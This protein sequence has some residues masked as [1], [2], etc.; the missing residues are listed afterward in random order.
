MKFYKCKTCGK[1]VMVTK[2][3]AGELV[4]CGQ[5]MEEIIPH[6]IEF[7][8]NEKHIPVYSQMNRKVNVKIGSIL[9]PSFDDH[10]IEWIMVVTNKG[11]HLTVLKPGEIPEAQFKLAK[12]EKILAIYEYCSIHSLWKL[13]VTEE[14]FKCCSC[15]D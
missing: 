9:H 13:E 11:H 3:G 4:C 8:G 7:E 14:M 10:Y 6:T 5:P 12:D 15:S 2:D 1:I